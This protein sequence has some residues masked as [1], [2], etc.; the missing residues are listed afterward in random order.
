[1]SLVP[2]AVARAFAR[3]RLDAVS[4]AVVVVVAAIVI[5]F[6]FGNA[7]SI[8][9]VSV[10]VGEEVSGDGSGGCTGCDGDTAICSNSLMPSVLVH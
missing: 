3:V 2:R 7:Y 10:V 9:W 6:I 4:V 8:G 5:I 1:M